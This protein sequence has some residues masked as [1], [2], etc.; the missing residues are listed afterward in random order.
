VAIKIA[1][2]AGLAKGINEWQTSFY[3]LDGNMD[4]YVWSVS[5]SLSEF[6][7]ETVI[8]NAYSGQVEDILSYQKTY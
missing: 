6:H 8:I 5:N 3:S 7:G 4:N 1:E 2:Q